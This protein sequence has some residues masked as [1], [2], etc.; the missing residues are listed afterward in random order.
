MEHVFQ[1]KEAHVDSPEA[2]DTVP[3]KKELRIEV[4]RLR[5][6]TSIFNSQFFLVRRHLIPDE[7]S[8]SGKH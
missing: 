8:R 5:R 6:L 1:E 7:V 2:T 3:K 4:S